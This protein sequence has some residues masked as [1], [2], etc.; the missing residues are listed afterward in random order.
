VSGDDYTGGPHRGDVPFQCQ[1]ARWRQ[2]TAKL[3]THIN[4]TG[5]TPAVCAEAFALKRQAER[6]A[7]HFGDLAD[8]GRTGAPPSRGHVPPRAMPPPAA[9][10]PRGPDTA[11]QTEDRG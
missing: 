6:L 8:R 5:A 3:L 11:S 2:A 9:R 4:A 7:G 1:V 10:R